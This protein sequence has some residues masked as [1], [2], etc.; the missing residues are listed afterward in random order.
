MDENTVDPEKWFNERF[1][2]LVEPTAL[3]NDNM[4]EYREMLR[5]FKKLVEKSSE[6]D[7]PK[8]LDA[9][10]GWGRDTNYFVRQGFD[11]VGIDKAP[12][13]L[14]YGMNRYDLAKDRLTRMDIENM[15]FQDGSFDAVWC[16]SVIFF[17]HKHEMAKPLSELSRVLKQGGILY[18]NFKLARALGKESYLREEY[19]GSKIK[20]YLVT[21]KEAENKLEELGIEVDDELSRVSENSKEGE[22]PYLALFC[23]KT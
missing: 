5:E 9:G 7:D 19:D 15:A 2:K 22:P 21:E 16:N 14:E 20:R 18:I 4:A 17:Y 8:I 3:E 12:K 6:R 10:C 11:A 13:P 1:E 23:R